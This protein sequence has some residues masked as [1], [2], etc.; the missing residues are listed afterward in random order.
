MADVELKIKS[1]SREAQ[2]DL[3]KLGSV[4]EGLSTTFKAVGAAIVAGFAFNKIA[5]GIGTVVDAAA[6]QEDA[7]SGMNQA[8]R[9]AGDFSVAASK[10]LQTFA[11]DLQSVSIIGDETTLQMLSLA[12]SF[13]VSN[14]MAKDLVTAASELSAATGM[15]LESAV[16]NLGKTMSGLTGE[17]G[18][19][20][21][22][23]RSLTAEQLKSGAA[24]DLVNRRFAGSALAKIQTYS[25]AVTQLSNSWGDFQEKIGEFI[26]KNKAGIG[27]INAVSTA[28]NKLGDIL[29][30]NR[31]SI[32]EVVTEGI[33]LLLDSLPTLVRV[34]AAPRQAI[35]GMVLLT[36]NW[37][38]V[39]ALLL[40]SFLSFDV[41]Q[42]VYN[43]VFDVIKGTFAGIVALVSEVVEALQSIPGATG[44]VENLVGVDLDA[45]KKK[46][47]D[48]GVAAVGMIGEDTVGV[49]RDKIGEMRDGV[50][51][52]VA[53][54]EEKFI[55]L[56]G[57]VNSTAE[58]FSGL[59]DQVRNASKAINDMPDTPGGKGGIG[60]TPGSSGS[61]TGAPGFSD[62]G[63]ALNSMVKA[64]TAFGKISASIAANLGG[65]V[66]GGQAVVG[67]SVG[68]LATAAGI[69]G[70]DAIAGLA[71]Q[72]AGATKEE[73]KKMAE[74]FAEGITQGVTALAENAP[75]FVQAL[76]DN[77]GPIVTALAAAMPQVALSLS[78]QAPYIAQSL[79]TQLFEGMRY[80]LDTLAPKFNEFGNQF[81]TGFS[82][83]WGKVVDTVTN[84]PSAIGEGMPGL[85]TAMSST[86]TEA[87]TDFGVGFKELVMDS[88][89]DAGMIFINELKARAQEVVD[90]FN[91]AAE[92]R[93]GIVGKV[94]GDGG[95]PLEVQAAEAL[96]FGLTGGGSGQVVQLNIDGRVLGQVIFDLNLANTRL[97]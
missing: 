63:F 82:D 70:G 50:T 78:E 87:L 74:D 72:L 37:I 44:I 6:K 95:K 16:R 31:E 13:G 56:D 22:A 2:R 17:L 55:A 89:K 51:D 24:I 91:P 1:D 36:G 34:I 58:A 33:A 73:A 48:V 30:N 4:G 39:N 65:G 71:T 26:T 59:G 86:L 18:E 61:T 29:D 28:L 94:S 62:L 75:I 96:G 43:G 76:A 12:K 40:E 93:G 45:I 52:F 15:S 53:L 66:A 49:F 38:E 23:M 88:F 68:A 83:A 20:L 14:D 9:S 7:V 11:S 92:G 69:P 3:K 32:D 67:A 57:F 64:A 85:L 90:A 27:G 97:A 42:K 60:A 8:L 41:V 25:G 47:D 46:L 79:I 35:R 80:Q 21:P 81:S 10:D 5:Q 54:S 84:I 77:A 19:S